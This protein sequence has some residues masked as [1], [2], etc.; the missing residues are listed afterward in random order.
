MPP[1]AQDASLRY[2]TH[3]DTYNVAAS[4]KIVFGEHSDSLLSSVANGRYFRRY[5]HTQVHKYV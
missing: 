3:T 1:L 4:A 2:P 5:L